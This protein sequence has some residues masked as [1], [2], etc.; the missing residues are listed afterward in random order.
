MSDWA[1]PRHPPSITRQR[2][3]FGTEPGLGLRKKAVPFREP[4]RHSLLECRCG[5]TARCCGN[6]NPT[7]L[8]APAKHMNTWTAAE[9]SPSRP[10][11]TLVELVLVIAIL[12]VLAYASERARLIFDTRPGIPP[13]ASRTRAEVSSDFTEGDVIGLE[14]CL[15]WTWPG[16]TQRRVTIR[17]QHVRQLWHDLS[18]LR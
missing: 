17:F 2:S 12:A 14:S 13:C 1:P 7:V 9:E 6:E 4:R 5:M 8:L 10:D 15:I 3:H 18:R 16:A 11:F